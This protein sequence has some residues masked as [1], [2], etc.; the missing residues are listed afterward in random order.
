[1]A[2]DWPCIRHLKEGQVTR[3]SPFIPL[4]GRS[5]RQGAGLPVSFRN[6]AHP[7]RAVLG[8]SDATSPHGCVVSPPASRTLV[9]SRT[10]HYH[11]VL[12]AIFSPFVTT[13]RYRLQHHTAPHRAAADLHLLHP[14]TMSPVHGPVRSCP[15]RL[16]PQRPRAILHAFWRQRGLHTVGW[17]HG[18]CTEHRLG[19][20]CT[21]APA[22]R[23]PSGP[24]AAR[25]V[26]SDNLPVA[27]A[28]TGV[29]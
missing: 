21:L 12:H 24:S 28:G 7:E 10:T 5:A 9:T 29:T 16:V 1:M 13:V 19:V 3:G 18:I 11:G 17:P 20:R 27:D 26:G 2:C 4:H 25:P 8:E 6:R 22:V 15:H 14:Q 23:M